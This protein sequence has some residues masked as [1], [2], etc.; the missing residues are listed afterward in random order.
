MVTTTNA[1]NNDAS[2]KD[3]TLN[4]LNGR[5]AR[6]GTTEVS[7]RFVEWWERSDV[8]HDT[9]DTL[10]V[11]ESKYVGR[12]DL[13]A[14]AFYGDTRLKWVIMQYNDI[15]DPSAE[16]TAGRL[17]LMP[18]TSKVNSAFAATV[19]GGKPTTALGV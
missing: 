14:Y 10:Y 12:P 4:Q 7:T 1:L 16:L 8:Q 15:L 6:G 2:V 3:S 18:T 13:L 19:I 11:L 9:S 5:Y 17:L